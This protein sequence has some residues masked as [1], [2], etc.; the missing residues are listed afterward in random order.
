M[1][2]PIKIRISYL[3]VAAL[4]GTACSSA[5]EPFSVTDDGPAPLALTNYV[6]VPDPFDSCGY[7]PFTVAIAADPAGWPSAEVANFYY[8]DPSHPA[9]TDSDNTYG[10]PDKP[11]STFAQFVISEGGKVVLVGDGNTY[12]IG[13]KG[14][15][16]PAMTGTSSNQIFI[17]GRCTTTRPQLLKQLRFTG[18]THV[19]VEGL[20][21]TENKKT[22][23]IQAGSHYITIRN[24][25]FDGPSEN[26][27]FT[28]VIGISGTDSN[29]R[30]SH[31]VVYDNLF[32]DWGENLITSPE[33]Y[34]HGVKPSA[35]VT[36]V[37]IVNNECHNLG[38]DC[39]QVGDAS[40]ADEIRPDYVY[41]TGN[42][43]YNNLEN[44][45]DIKEADDIIISGNI[46]HSF[47][48]ALSN[49]TGNSSTAMVV[50]D[51]AANVWVLNNI[52]YD[53]GTGIINTGGLNVHMLGNLIYDVNP[54]GPYDA[55]TAYGN[56]QCMHARGTSSGV[57]AFNTC[58]SY[59]TGINFGGQI[60]YLVSGNIFSERNRADGYEIM[61]PNSGA[62]TSF[63]GMDFNVFHNSTQATQFK[64]GST[65]Q[66]LSAWGVSTGF[67]VNALTLDP[68]FGNA[69]AN[70]FTLQG[71]SP[72]IDATG[73]E[74]QVFSDFQTRYG[75]D[76]RSDINGVIRPANGT[77]DRGAFEA[78]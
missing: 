58:V 56:G 45:V 17:E 52:L 21:W 64:R 3:F 76:I 6:G 67:E 73:P 78:N 71:S 2:G 19:I 10:Y 55:A 33:N 28:S 50:H 25:L 51:D 20:M 32:K 69:G 72:A 42:V 26:V 36:Q 49:N 39:V 44:C 77:W 7:D 43:M 61:L 57:M 11:R 54:V 13:G 66:D 38:G 62:Y 5:D 31:I 30:S 63:T 23:S 4:L 34:Y 48:R 74:L 40:I 37:W 14:R 35:N 12:T 9:S 24:S 1:G 65:V 75:L 22:A 59:A 15:F 46:C 41:I 68:A 18:S 8:I 60:P 70:D 47:N 16:E 27:G 29:D 53:I